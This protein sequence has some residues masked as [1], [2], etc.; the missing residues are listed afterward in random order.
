MHKADAVD[1][2]YHFLTFM[3]KQIFVAV[4]Y[5]VSFDDSVGGMLSQKHI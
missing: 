5:I 2:E 3:V 4:I 1:V